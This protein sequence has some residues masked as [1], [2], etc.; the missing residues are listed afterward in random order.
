MYINPF[1]RK[2]EE[3]AKSKQRKV[4]SLKVIENRNL[5]TEHLHDEVKELNYFG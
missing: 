2:N 4:L 3:K 1:F 5:N